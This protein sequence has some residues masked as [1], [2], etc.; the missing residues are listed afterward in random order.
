MKC[1][2]IGGVPATGKT[3]LVKKIINIL[4]PKHELSFGLLKGQIVG[5]IAILGV[6]KDSEVFAGTDK[7]SMAVQSHFDKYKDKNHKH[8]LF[9]GDRLFTKN[10]LESLIK[11]HETKIIIL[12]ADEQTLTKRH[13]D[14]NDNQNEKFLK[15]RQTKINNIK[16]SELLKEHIEF[17][18]LVCMDESDLLAK[19]CCSFLLP[20]VTK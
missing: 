1:I 15:G 11:T 6:Y 4:E 12:E 13:I 17:H 7:L 5:D 2:A 18:N 16:N 19:D 9:E 3:T 14:R 8:L 10:N 20:V